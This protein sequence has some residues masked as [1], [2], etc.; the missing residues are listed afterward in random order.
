MLAAVVPAMVPHWALG[1]HLVGLILLA[2]LASSLIA[3]K[4]L[5]THVVAVA[6]AL[7]RFAGSKAAGRLFR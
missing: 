4:S 5:E 1:W 3:Q 6:G 7:E 2:I